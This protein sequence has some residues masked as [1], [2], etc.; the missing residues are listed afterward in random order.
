MISALLG[1]LLIAVLVSIPWMVQFVVLWI[2]RHI[3]KGSR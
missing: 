3:F 2:W 1:F